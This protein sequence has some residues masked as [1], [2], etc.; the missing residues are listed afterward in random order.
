MKINHKK[1]GTKERKGRR[2]M[3]NRETVSTVPVHTTVAVLEITDSGAQ[4]NKPEVA[5]NSN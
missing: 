2:A 4:M 3:S 1:E 5:A